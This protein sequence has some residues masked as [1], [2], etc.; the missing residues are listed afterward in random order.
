M[1]FLSWHQDYNNPGTNDGAPGPLHENA[2]SGRCRR[3]HWQAPA[4]LRTIAFTMACPFFM[5][6]TKSDAAWF[7]HPSRLPL[8]AEWN[9]QCSA[10]GHEHCEPDRDELKNCN[11]GYAVKCPRLPPDRAADAIR[12]SIARDSGS[13][14][15]L[16]FVHERDH[17][18]AGHGILEY[19]VLRAA[20]TSPHVDPRIQKMA[21]CY[22]Q[23]YLQRRTFPT[24][25]NS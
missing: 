6:T 15:T 8:G 5:P 17:R 25:T 9:G 7:L 19:D 23:S 13:H 2:P 3:D 21:E 11:L 24:S 10:P 12:F 18:P 14:L 20:W 4:H 16:W 1:S 22:L